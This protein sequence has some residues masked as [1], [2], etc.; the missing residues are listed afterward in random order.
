M[1]TL[2]VFKDVTMAPVLFLKGRLK[3]LPSFAGRKTARPVFDEVKKLAS[4][5]AGAAEEPQ[6]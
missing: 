3:L 6:P 5:S 1:G 2:N 4:R